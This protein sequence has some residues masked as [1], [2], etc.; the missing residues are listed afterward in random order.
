MIE[1][2]QLSLAYCSL[3]LSLDDVTKERDTI[4]EHIAEAVKTLAQERIKSRLEIDQLK[5]DARTQ[6]KGKIV[7]TMMMTQHWI[8]VTLS[9]QLKH[10]L[11]D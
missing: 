2:Y 4:N 8:I 9:F 10:T 1:Y 7:M 5:K 6:D 3:L 11:I